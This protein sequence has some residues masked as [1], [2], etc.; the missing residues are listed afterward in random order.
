MSSRKEC[1]IIVHI[2]SFQHLN[3]NVVLEATGTSLD[4]LFNFL[5]RI[6]TTP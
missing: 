3:E 1:N 2:P 6:V 5:Q 4:L